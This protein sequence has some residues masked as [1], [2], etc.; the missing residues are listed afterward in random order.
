[1]SNVISLRSSVIMACE[2]CESTDFEL[3]GRGSIWCSTCKGSIM[4][5]WEAKPSP[6]PTV[7]EPAAGDANLQ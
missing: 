5:R 4:A 1:M 7:V 2:N 6:A 3:H